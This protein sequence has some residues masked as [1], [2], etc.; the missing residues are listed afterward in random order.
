MKRILLAFVLVIAA[1][2]AAHAARDAACWYRGLEQID[3]TMNP[4]QGGDHAFFTAADVSPSLLWVLD[5]SGSMQTLPCNADC[6]N[7]QGCGTLTSYNRSFFRQEGYAGYTNDASAYDAFDPDFCSTPGNERAFSGKDG[8]YKPSLVYR[9]H[10]SGSCGSW[11]SSHQ[12]WVRDG[13]NDAAATIEGWCAREYPVS[14]PTSP[15]NT[16]T[17]ST[18]CTSDSQCHAG[19]Q[20]LTSSG[21]SSGSNRRCRIPNDC[22]PGSYSCPSGYECT[23]SGDC[24]E[25]A[26]ERAACIHQLRTYGYHP[27]SNASNPVFTG[28][29][30]NFYPPK[31][32]VARKTVKDVVA[33]VQK[34]RQGLMVFNTS[35][36]GGNGDGGRL[37]TEL[38]PTCDKFV[39]SSGQAVYPSQEDFD[40]NVSAIKQ[41]IDQMKFVDGTPLGETL[42]S[43]CQYF[44]GNKKR[45]EDVVRVRG[46]A[47]V[48]G[49]FSVVPD[50]S[51]NQDPFCV[52]C[53]KS[54]VAVITD[55]SPSSDDNVPCKLRNYDRDCKEGLAGTPS[56][57]S[58]NTRTCPTSERRTYPQSGGYDYFDDV[59]AF[60]ANEDLRPDMTGGQNV[61]THTV[62]FGIRAPILE[63]AARMGG[64]VQLYAD[65]AGQLRNALAA[66]V[67]NI[68]K[69]ATSFSVSAVTTVQSRGSTYAFIPRFRPNV[70]DL[71]EGHLYRYKLV[72]EFA[73]GC[74]V[75]DTV[76]E[77]TADK[78]SRNPNGDGDC[79]DVYLADKFNRF[80]GEDPDGNYMLAD[81]T[82]PYDDDEEGWPLKVPPEPAE[83]VWDATESLLSRNL[84]S[85][86]DA[87]KIFT[88]VDLDGDG[89]LEPNEQIDFKTT[90]V[91]QLL[92]SLALGGRNGA[93]CT[94][95]ASRLD[96]SSFSSERDCAI[97]LIKYV[98]GIDLFDEDEDGRKDD[99]RPTILGDIFH[100]SPTLVTAPVMPV[101][102][103]LGVSTQCIHS[104]YSERLTPQGIS[105]YN[106]W[107]LDN[108]ERT[109]FVLVGANDGMLHA[110]HAGDWEDGDDPDTSMPEQR[111]LTLGTGRELWAFIP[112]DMLPKLK[113]LAVRTGRHDLFVDG[114]P[115]VRDVWVDSAKNP[116]KKDPEEFRTVA[117]VGERQGG[118]SWFALDVTS[119]TDP[120]FRWIYPPIGSARALAAGESW[121]DFAPAAPPIG[122][123]AV[124]DAQGPLTIGE[125]KAK[126]VWTVW[127]NGGYDAALAR[128]RSLAALD[129]WTGQELWRFSREDASGSSDRR[130]DL[131]P[132]AATMSLLDLG[133]DVMTHELNKDGLFDTAVVGDLMGQV[134]T[135]RFHEPGKD[136]NGDGVFDNWHAARAFVQFKGDSLAKR[137]PFFQMAEAVISPED[138]QVRVYL[139]SGDRANIR[140]MAGGQCSVVNPLACIRKG[141]EV[142]YE[143]VKN[144]FG[145]HSYDMSLRQMPN[146]TSFTTNTFTAST[147]SPDNAC[148]DEIDQH[149]SMRLSCVSGALNVHWQWRLQ[150]DWDD[151]D[152]SLCGVDQPRPEPILSTMYVSTP[153]THARFYGFTLFD[154]RRK[155]FNTADEAALYDARALTDGDLV[156]AEQASGGSNG[157]YVDFAH[158]DER[159]SSAAVVMS[160]CVVW[161][162]LKPDPTPLA[163]GTRVADEGRQYRAHYATGSRACGLLDDS[164]RYVLKRSIV[165]PPAATPVVAFNP[166]T[167]DVRYQVLNVQAG[168]A[169]NQM[170]VGAST[171]SGPVFWL[172]TPREVHDCRHGT[173]PCEE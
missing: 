18:Y 158:A 3:Q 101:L 73:A 145:K 43:A 16:R 137:H 135:V 6:G 38:G 173:G 153:T 93:F 110:F 144:H 79:D 76:G 40:A 83:P 97:E 54:F 88:V 141:C 23:A 168:Q 148:S 53:Q 100:S 24:D 87:R 75:N 119:P 164:Q 33:S 103:D 51:G 114:T 55:G 99:P 20:C 169:P 39:S 143:P 61:I 49:S 134:W 166:K 142:R 4:P 84:T 106:Q 42:T 159:V 10:N 161:S 30:L 151:G 8:C 150:C 32:V 69:R 91:D 72:S 125:Q 98:T 112:P 77:M 116:R 1:S 11:P 62:G 22:R 56:C 12:A 155:P 34:T 90:T 19:W 94:E 82:E 152:G 36:V 70:T 78:L 74:T 109:Q 35:G 111:R 139:G 5:N 147:Y 25:N 27:G 64:G 136:T 28:D 129:V 17:N 146:A 31:F 9:H 117:V 26:D 57:S 59:A 13:N 37:L 96:R 2:P 127:L 105:A 149:V 133:N 122:P 130:R 154:S 165:P 167:G 52:S 63:D 115:M 163:C 170:Q 92:P 123:V 48:G 85:A 102:C 104:L 45:F 21:S 124:A 172:E 60:C 121:N 67:Q 80:V 138:G 29:L 108:R 15:R 160:G 71:W 68:S 50:R 58:V 46:S 7:F 128:G 171:L 86:S 14:T 41:Q 140:D 157:W 113:R 156:D 126:E 89:V 120:K 66:V 81:T 65:N 107:V 118:R 162:T 131:A 47:G 95:F 132:V 44:S